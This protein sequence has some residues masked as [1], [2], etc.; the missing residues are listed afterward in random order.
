MLFP[1]YRQPNPPGR[2]AGRIGGWAAHLPRLS[3]APQPDWLPQPSAEGREPAPGPLGLSGEQ[4]TDATLA[5]GSPALFASPEGS[6]PTITPV[7]G[8]TSSAPLVTKT[9]RSMRCAPTG[10]P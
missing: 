2:T 1:G 7:G 8:H 4:P 9:Q 10:G 5:A 6:S 3:C